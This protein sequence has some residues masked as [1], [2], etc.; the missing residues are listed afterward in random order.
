[1]LLVLTLILMAYQLGSVGNSFQDL[2][3]H[4]ITTANG[5][6]DNQVLLTTLS[7][8]LREAAMLIAPVL[9]GSPS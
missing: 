6:L 9:M 2:S 4:V 1:M 3:R 8:A 7:D 5:Q